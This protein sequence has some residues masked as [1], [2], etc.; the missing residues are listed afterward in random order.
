MKSF[1]TPNQWSYTDLFSTG[2][3]MNHKF[4]LLWLMLFTLLLLPTR[5]V[6]ETT[7][8]DPRYTLFNSLDGISDVTITDNGSYPWKML[9]LKADG[10]E[11]FTIP[12]G[13]K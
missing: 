6:A 5:M 1:A 10:M 11:S 12:D 7:T 13:S 8:E 9:D 2:R 3:T 4:S